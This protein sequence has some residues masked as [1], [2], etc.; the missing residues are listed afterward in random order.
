L[1]SEEPSDSYKGVA[2]KLVVQLKV[3]SGLGDEG[4]VDEKT[5]DALNV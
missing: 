1:R 3:Q 5:A 4:V 2:V